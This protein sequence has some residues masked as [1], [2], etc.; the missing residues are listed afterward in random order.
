MKIVVSLCLLNLPMEWQVLILI[1]VAVSIDRSKVISL[2]QSF[3]GCMSVIVTAPFCLVI[4]KTRLFKY[5]ENLST[6]K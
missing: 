2:L 6:K 4:T 1:A 3:F 5:T